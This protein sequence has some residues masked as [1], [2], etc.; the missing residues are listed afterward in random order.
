[1]E[2]HDKWFAEFF[3]QYPFAVAMVSAYTPKKVAQLLAGVERLWRVL[4]V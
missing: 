2:K 4:C 3:R 1:M